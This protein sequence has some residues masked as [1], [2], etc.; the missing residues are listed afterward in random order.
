[1]PPPTATKST[2]LNKAN[3]M[4][5][6]PSPR[7]RKFLI[8]RTM[9]EPVGRKAKLPWLTPFFNVNWL[10]ANKSRRANFV[11]FVNTSEFS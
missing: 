10:I 7:E 11:T 9:I 8:R 1:M 2:V 6:F 5:I 4:A 3:V